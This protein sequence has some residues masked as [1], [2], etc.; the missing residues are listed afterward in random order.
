MHEPE[1]TDLSIC[2]D[3]SAGAYAL[4]ADR[5]AFVITAVIKRSSFDVASTRSSWTNTTQRSSAGKHRQIGEARARTALER[6]ARRLGAAPERG[7]TDE[8]RIQRRDLTDDKSSA[9]A[10]DAV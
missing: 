9:G 5:G 10:D 2:R 4:G 1:L 8:V 7:G 6:E 3:V